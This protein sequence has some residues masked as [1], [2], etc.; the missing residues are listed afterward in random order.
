MSAAVLT[1]GMPGPSNLKHVLAASQEA[2][3]PVTGTSPTGRFLASAAKAGGSSSAL[4]M[5]CSQFCCALLLLLSS[6]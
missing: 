3:L 4:S 6:K 2:H 5:S 1:V